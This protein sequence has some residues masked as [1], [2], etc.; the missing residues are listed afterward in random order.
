MM[1]CICASTAFVCRTLCKQLCRASQFLDASFSQTPAQAW[2]AFL[3]AQAQALHAVLGTGDAA[4]GAHRAAALAR[5]D[6]A[7]ECLS[8]SCPGC[9]SSSSRAFWKGPD[10]TSISLITLNTASLPGL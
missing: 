10:D 3:S 7:A 9:S 8:T 4:I 5:P 2:H 1:G 6:V